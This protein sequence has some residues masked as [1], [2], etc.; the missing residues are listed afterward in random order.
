MKTRSS[1]RPVWLVAVLAV[2]MGLAAWR[3]SLSAQAAPPAS[4]WPNGQRMAL[5]L[6]F[7]DGRD[8][9]VL[10]GTALLKRH[11]AAVTFFVVPSA[12]ERQLAGWKQAVADGHEIGNHSLTH[13]CSGNFAWA[14]SKALEDYTIERMRKELTE[15]NR[16]VQALLGATPRT[17]AY[18]CGQSFVGRGRG[19]KSYVPIVARLFVAG[20]GWLDESANDPAF[21]DLA[22][23]MGVEM[24][25]REFSDLRP[26]IEETR[27]RSG[28]LVLAGHEIGASGRQ[29]THVTMLEEL[30]AFA[31]DPKEGVW[32]APVGVIA[33]HVRAQQVKRRLPQPRGAAVAPRLPL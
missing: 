6:S 20:R 25:G 24:D 28:W 2:A 30:L 10:V 23:L 18:P 31:K 21:V 17:F 9:Q 5:S 26:L 15:T 3:P 33:E 4:V 27:S 7:D 22:Q 13:P 29:T 8:S 16:R 19:T 14:R 1:S 11:G 12:V 32:L